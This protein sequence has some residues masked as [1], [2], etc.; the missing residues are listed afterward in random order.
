MGIIFFAQSIHLPFKNPKTKVLKL[1]AGRA[2]LLALTQE[3]LFLLGNNAYGQ[4][5]RTIIPEEDY[6]ASNYINHIEKID[7]KTIVDVE[8]GQDHRYLYNLTKEDH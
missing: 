5:S 8:C 7:G 6:S 4:C 2:H 1:A 3:G